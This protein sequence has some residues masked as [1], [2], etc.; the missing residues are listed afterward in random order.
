MNRV[1]DWEAEQG[2][3]NPI[4]SLNPQGLLFF[5]VGIDDVIESESHRNHPEQM[6]TRE[7]LPLQLARKEIA[8]YHETA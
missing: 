3:C 8:Q 4:A 2:Q 6:L 7:N 1:I 5:F